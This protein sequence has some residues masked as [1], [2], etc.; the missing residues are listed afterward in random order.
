MHATG[1]DPT[2]MNARPHRTEPYCRNREKVWCEANGGVTSPCLDEGRE[3]AQ[4]A[5]AGVA[6]GVVPG[7]HGGSDGRI[8]KAQNSFGKRVVSQT[9]VYLVMLRY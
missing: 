1:S 9:E 7:E 6:K 3:R 5:C 4:V 8:M 2:G